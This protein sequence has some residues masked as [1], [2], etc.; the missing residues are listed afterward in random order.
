MKTIAVYTDCPVTAYVHMRL[1]EIAEAFPC[2]ASFN[3]KERLITIK[4]MEIHAAS[5][6]FR[7]ADLV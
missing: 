2:I 4:C 3:V 7:L 5:I 6:E 1:D